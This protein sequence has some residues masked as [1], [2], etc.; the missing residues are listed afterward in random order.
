MNVLSRAHRTLKTLINYHDL[1]GSDRLPDSAPTL[2][3]LSAGES[4]VGAYVNDPS[5]F[6]DLV[7]FSTG[8]IYV[9]RVGRWE[10]VP[11]VKIVRTVAPENKEKVSGFMLQLNDGNSFWV[12]VTGSK[13]GRFF[14][15]FEVLRF[16]DRVL[17]DGFPQK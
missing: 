12:P 3:A 2:P 9:F 16:V 10:H 5:A 11:F 7:L 8:G 6:S 14:D 15:A 17:A 4:V 13:A 1:S